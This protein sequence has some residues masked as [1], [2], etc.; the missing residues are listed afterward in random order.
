M[1]ACRG[2]GWR[3]MRMETGGWGQVLGGVG[4]TC[5]VVEDVSRLL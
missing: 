5:Q 4:G 3:A 2:W 1:P